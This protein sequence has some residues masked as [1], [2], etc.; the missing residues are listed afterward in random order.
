M[1]KHIPTK[2]LIRIFKAVKPKQASYDS[3]ES[4][5]FVLFK[6]AYMTDGQIY[7]ETSVPTMADGWYRVVGNTLLAWPDDAGPTVDEI[8]PPIAEW[9]HAIGNNSA[10][11]EFPREALTM[12]ARYTRKS[13]ERELWGFVCLQPKENRIDIV[14]TD[15]FAATRNVVPAQSNLTDENILIPERIVK[16]LLMDKTAKTLTV[17]VEHNYVTLRTEHLRITW[18]SGVTAY[19]NINQLIPQE[20]EYV[21]SVDISEFRQAIRDL[22]H[23]AESKQSR[24]KISQDKHFLTLFADNPS[25]YL[26]HSIEIPYKIEVAPSSDYLQRRVPRTAQNVALIM[27]MT[28]NEGKPDEH[29]RIQHQYLAQVCVGQRGRLYFGQSDK[30]GAYAPILFSSEPLTGGEMR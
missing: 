30:F 3:A 14:A 12:A 19:Y 11:M 10:T 8:N 20:L 9:P 27:P 24:V 7:V 4:N 1:A 29:I 22:K 5:M 17:T 13:K 23:F 16:I 28:N 15:Q 2:D 21:L 18:Y 25:K 26:E 6:Q